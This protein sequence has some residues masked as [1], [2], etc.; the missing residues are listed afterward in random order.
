MNHE[1]PFRLFDGIVTG[2]CL[3]LMGAFATPWLSNVRDES[4]GRSCENHLKLI[5]KACLS[6]ADAQQQSLPSNRRHPHAGWN[7]LILPYMEQEEL[8]EKY[9]LSRDWW[10]EEN[11]Q[12]GLNS[13]PTLMCPSAPHSD[14]VIRLLDPNGKEFV[15]AA[16]DYVA[17]SGA[18][19]HTNQPERLYRGAMASP[20]RHYG[21]SNVTTGHAIRLSDIADGRANSFL[22]VEMADK[23]NEWRRGKLHAH[24]TA[25]KSHKPLVEGFSF[26]QWIAPNWNHLRSYDL[27]GKYQF[28]HCAVNCSNGGS[29]YSFHPGKSYAGMADGS[30]VRLRAGLEQEV[31][32]ALVSIAD[33]E[34]IAIS[35]Y[36]VRD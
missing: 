13:L 7:T 23:P 15:A 5:A 27:E 11:R 22:V 34:L 9:D 2:V 12:V 17:S 18:Y 21:G 16:T 19:L 28:G 31:M 29:I 1:R 33:G 26:G 35:D 20:G 32:V 8:Y 4:R 24:A 30:V 6:F 10:E 3:L 36:S 25:E 14:R